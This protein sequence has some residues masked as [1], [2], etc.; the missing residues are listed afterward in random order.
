MLWRILLQDQI[1]PVVLRNSD[2]FL[3]DIPNSHPWHL[4]ANAH[5]ALFT[6]HLNA[7]LDWDMFQT[8]HEYGAYHAAAR[9]LS[10]GPIVITDVPG[11]HDLDVINQ[12]VAPSPD[13]GRSVVLR[14][15]PGKTPRAFDHYLESGI[16]K[17]VSETAAGAKLM[18]LFNTGETPV[19]LLVA[20]A[21]F[22]NVGSRPWQSESEIVL[23]SHRTQTPHGPLPLKQTFPFHSDPASLIQTELP[24]KAFD[25]LSGH[26]VHRLSCRGIDFR[27]CV[28]GP[29]GKMTGAAAVCGSAITINEEGK[30]SISIRMKALGLFGIWIC[31][32]GL[33]TKRDQIQARLE[34]SEF[35]EHMVKI[36]NLAEGAMGSQLLQL[37]LLELWSRQGRFK[38]CCQHVTLCVV[39]DV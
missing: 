32:S 23:F 35:D 14:P 18:G 38:D 13:R 1:P 31:A 24:T 12:I 29:L 16:L 2:D 22:A 19:S 39:F 37:D 15:S 36:V 3:P 28:L 34:D 6:Q 26:E 20:V 17:I 4:W 9:C 25:I 8:S 27:V 10:G 33:R 5:N 11:E 21:E 7:V 30:L